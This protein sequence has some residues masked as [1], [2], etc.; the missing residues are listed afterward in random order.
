M[1]EVEA[2]YVK[3]GFWINLERGPIMGRTLTVNIET[4]TIIIA[5]LAILSSLAMTHL[6]HL[7]T[8]SQHQFRAKGHPRDGLFQQQQ[9]LLRTLSPPSAF[10]ADWLKLWWLWRKRRNSALR[11]SIPQLFLAL[12]F[13]AATVTVGIFSSYTASSTKLQVLVQNPRCSPLDLDP[14]SGNLIKNLGRLRKYRMTIVS[15]SGPFAEE[16]YQNT[17]S[18]P[19]RCTAFVSPNIRLAPKRVQ[20]PFD[21]KICAA[22]E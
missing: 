21:K 2:R 12:L 1:S 19:A 17:T 15:R 10:A 20:C 8:F 5:L 22:K 9:V 14:T 3:R 16:C 6:W 13:T 18:L 4:G 11:R 7:V